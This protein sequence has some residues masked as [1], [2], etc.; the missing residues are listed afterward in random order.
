MLEKRERNKLDSLTSRDAY[1]PPDSL[2][3]SAA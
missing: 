2:L 1:S 3:G